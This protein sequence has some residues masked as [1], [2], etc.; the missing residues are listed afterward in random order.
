ME[1]GHRR[2]HSRAVAKGRSKRQVFCQLTA[3]VDCTISQIWSTAW[4]PDGRLLALATKSKQILLL[5]VRR[6]DSLVSCASHDSLRPVRIAWASSSHLLTSGFTRAA[7]RELILYSAEL[8]NLKPLAHETLDVSPAPLFPFA[9]IDTNIIILYSRGE[10]T[11]QAFEVQPDHS[12]PFSKLPNFET[13][14]LQAGWAFLPKQ[15]NDVR[16]VEII[17]ALRLT[18][19]TIEQ[20]SFTVPRAKVSICGL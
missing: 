19:S 1:H 15:R 14:T 13:G 12:K 6:P 16:N 4:S 9:D 5:D 3:S 2:L 10:R 11:C 20:V 8:N 7:S 18:Q 17:S